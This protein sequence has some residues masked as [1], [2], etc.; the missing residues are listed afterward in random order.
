[1]IG[2]GESFAGFGQYG[3]PVQPEQAEVVAQPAKGQHDQQAFEEHDRQGPDTATGFATGPFSIG[4]VQRA[5]GPH[6]AAQGA[7]LDRQRWLRVHPRRAQCGVAGMGLRSFGQAGGDLCERITGRGSKL[8]IAFGLNGG[9]APDYRLQLL[10]LQHLRRRGRILGQR[11][12]ET[13]LPVD[14]RACLAQGGDVAIDR[15]LQHAQ[16]ARQPRGRRRR[17]GP[18]RRCCKRRSR[19]A[20]GDTDIL[21]TANV[22]MRQS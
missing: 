8:G 17:R 9:Q 21:L 19:R 13:H 14:D 20:E 18:V 16:L 2:G 3:D 12:V 1:M 15:P 10:Q 11:V 6:G 7:G 22:R 4:D 5:F